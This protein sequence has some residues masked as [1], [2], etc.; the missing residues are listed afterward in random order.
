MEH[1]LIQIVSGKAKEVVEVVMLQLHL[2]KATYTLGTYSLFTNGY[3]NNKLML[4][5]TPKKS[6]RN[7]CAARMSTV[8]YGLEFTMRLSFDWRN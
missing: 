6:S 8:V 2:T 5:S 7:G 3:V 1:I 4:S